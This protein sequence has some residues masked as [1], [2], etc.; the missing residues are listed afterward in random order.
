[1]NQSTSLRWQ[2]QLAAPCDEVYRLL[3][4]DGGRESFWVERSERAGDQLLFSYPGGEQLAAR[5]LAEDPGRLFVMSHF[6]GSRLSFTLSE[7]D[8]GTHLL[9]EETGL[10]PENYVENRAGWVSVLMALKARA[11][12]GIDLRNHHPERH[13]S[14]G[15]PDN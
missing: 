4:T 15:Y 14:A 2:L 5:V 9:L 12:H 6:D 7:R 8:G 1:M 10:T 3:S 13:W 11:E